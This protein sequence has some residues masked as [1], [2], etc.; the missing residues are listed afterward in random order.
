[1]RGRARRGKLRA[2]FFPHSEYVEATHEARFRQLAIQLFLASIAVLVMISR[3]YC[4]YKYCSPATEAILKEFPVHI[5]MPPSQFFFEVPTL[6]GNVFVRPQ[7]IRRMDEPFCLTSE[8]TPRLG[9]PHTLPRT[10]VNAP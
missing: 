9:L 2:D 6:I 1:M 7:L 3:C 4:S 5:N 8:R 10:D